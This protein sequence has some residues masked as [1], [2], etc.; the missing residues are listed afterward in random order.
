MVTLSMVG[1]VWLSMVNGCLAVSL[2]LL[3]YCINTSMNVSSPPVSN[4]M[5]HECAMFTADFTNCQ[6]IHKS[7]I[8]QKS[9]TN[10]NYHILIDY[11]SLINCLLVN[12]WSITHHW[13]T[14]QLNREP[15][16][17]I[18]TFIWWVSWFAHW[19]TELMS[20]LASWRG[21]FPPRPR[22]VSERC[23]DVRAKRGGDKTS[24]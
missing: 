23:G 4:P 22:W 8:N 18:S 3:T 2:G 15:N 13:S 20:N 10:F 6:H 9:S 21:E 16:H 7:F 19:L 11:Q 1:N 17:Q 12:H 5:L 14:N 24:C